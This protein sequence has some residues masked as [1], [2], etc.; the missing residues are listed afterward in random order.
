MGTSRRVEGTSA[1]LACERMHVGGTSQSLWDVIVH[2]V[3]SSVSLDG[4]GNGGAG[5]KGE[6]FSLSE[7]EGAAVHRGSALCKAAD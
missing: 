4:G 7:A 3:S 6:S 1:A 2:T 5:E